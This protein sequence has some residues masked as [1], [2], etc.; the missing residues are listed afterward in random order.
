MTNLRRITTRAELV[1]LA[2]ELGMRHD[3]HE[4]DEKGVTAY[5]E[6]SD[7]DFDN[8][9]FWPQR[10]GYGY[11][12]DKDGNAR[13]AELHVFLARKEWDE[14]ARV[15]RRGPDIAVVNL[16]TLFAWASEPHEQ[17]AQVGD[18]ISQRGPI[19]A[20]VT[21]LYEAVGP[22][23]WRR[24]DPPVPFHEEGLDYGQTYDWTTEHG[25]YATDAGL[26]MYAPLKVTGVR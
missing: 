13:R 3:W 19:S 26:L 6:G 25:G 1:E 8:A 14:A 7:L 9:G 21:E 18:Y 4:P 10:Q 24:A 2:R 15:Y 5:V 20:N 17:P 16:A 22:T 23:T 11:D 12:R